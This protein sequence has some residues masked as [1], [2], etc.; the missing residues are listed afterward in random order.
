MNH[1][2]DTIEQVLGRL[3]ISKI[4]PQVKALTVGQTQMPVRIWRQKL[5]KKKPQYVPR[6]TFCLRMVLTAACNQ[7]ST[8]E[9]NANETPPA[10]TVCNLQEI[11]TI[12]TQRHNCIAV[13]SLMTISAATNLIKFR[14]LTRDVAAS[15]SLIGHF[16]TF[17]HLILYE[18]F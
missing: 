12:A 8:K 6:K 10:Q 16:S 5:R 3:W 17:T 13:R 15:L 7:K 2:Q 11:T 14:L 9:E 18:P 1:N 4:L